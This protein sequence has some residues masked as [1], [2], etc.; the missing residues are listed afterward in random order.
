MS[1]LAFDI[2]GANLKA[3][4]GCGWAQIVPF[5]LWRN[6]A[7]LSAA[8]VALID[9][10]PTSERIA[11]TMTGELCDCFATKAA[12]VRHI[13]EA[14]TSAAA[15]RDMVVYLVDGRL[16]S[17]AEAWEVPRLAAAS[18][19]HALARF[20]CRYIDGEVGLLIDIGSTTTDII[21]LVGGQPRPSGWND[22]RRLLA[23]ELVYT[24]VVR[25][26]V[27]AITRSLPWRGQNCPVAAELFATAEDVYVILDC[28]KEQPESKSTADGRPSTN[29]FARARLARMICADSVDFNAADARQAAECVQQA[30][31]LEL[32][33]ALRQVIDA[34]GR[35]PQKVVICGSGEFLAKRLTELVL[36][37][38]EIVPLGERLGGAVAAAATAHALAMLASEAVTPVR[39]KTE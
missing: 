20:A 22:T 8:L 15:G 18:N 7:G 33:R 30:Q 26:P 1:W 11:V 27:C 32:G 24:G 12:G 5:E 21:P 13:L 3:A 34:L 10:A 14:A 39:K 29:E 38:T 19:W 6:P 4:D 23:G 25:T 2:G 31:L 28:I 17:I 36:G 37:K 35:T 9:A 16:V